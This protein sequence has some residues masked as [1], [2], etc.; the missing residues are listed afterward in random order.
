MSASDTPCA[1]RAVIPATG[2]R[3]IAGFLKRPSGDL[4]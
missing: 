1:L 4:H 3:L 2:R